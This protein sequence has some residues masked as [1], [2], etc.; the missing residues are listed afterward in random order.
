MAK[1]ND[2]VNFDENSL[3]I[4][5][6]VLGKGGLA[7][8]KDATYNEIPV[9]VK[10]AKEQSNNAVILR[11]YHYLNDLQKS[12]VAG[13]PRVY[14]LFRNDGKQSFIMKKLGESLLSIVERKPDQIFRWDVTMVIAMQVLQRLKA[15]HNCGILHNDI[16]A[17]N[18][19]VGKE[20]SKTV[21]LVDFGYASRYKVNGKHVENA[22]TNKI[23]GT[24]RFCSIN[25][26]EGRTL[27][28]RDD[29]E[30]LAY[31]LLKL[32]TGKL[33]WDSL[34]SSYN[35]SKEIKKK[36]LIQ[37]KNWTAK[38]IC[39]GYHGCD[40]IEEFLEE[41]KQL[42]FNETPNYDKYCKIFK[43]RLKKKGYNA[44]DIEFR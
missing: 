39:K 16:K 1:I 38:E 3:N 23:L 8:V 42:K 25:S 20:D 14:F 29:L 19:L 7:V 30:S 37:R 36:R 6:G 34:M 17:D 13:V 28:R 43:K 18:L 32:R 26:L 41:V 15:I 2:K 10:E 11:E 27:S 21:Y 9:A 4:L 22:K 44:G 31:V 40:E 35:L 24:W 5:E 33:P 12:N